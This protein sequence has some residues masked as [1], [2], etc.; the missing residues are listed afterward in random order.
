VRVVITALTMVLIGCATPPSSDPS[1]VDASCA[2]QCSVNLTACSSTFTFFPV[3][4]QKQCNDTYDVCIKGCPARSSKATPSP[5]VAERLKT[6]DDLRKAGAI[7]DDE[8]ATRRKAIL[9]SL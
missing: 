4:H 9:D 7:N 3:V 2:Q 8:Y 6:L 1:L 5:S